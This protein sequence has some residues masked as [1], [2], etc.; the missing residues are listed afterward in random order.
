MCYLHSISPIIAND[1]SAYVAN[2]IGNMYALA[3]P[4]NCPYLVRT[5]LILDPCPYCPYS[6]EK[7]PYFK[8]N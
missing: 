8:R 4:A 2:D 3:R 1:A 6:G 5:V 7:C